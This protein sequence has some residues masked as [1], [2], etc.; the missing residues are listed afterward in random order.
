MTIEIY[1]TL[2]RSMQPFRPL[3]SGK[4]AHVRMRHDD[5]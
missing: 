1:N 4:R 5:L 2:T 3:E